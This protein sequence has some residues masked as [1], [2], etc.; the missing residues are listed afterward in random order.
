[1]ILRVL[2]TS[3]EMVAAGGVGAIKN[4]DQQ[5]GDGCA[6]TSEPERTIELSLEN[7]SVG[8]FLDSLGLSHL[9]DIFEKEQITMDILVE[10]G[11]DEL[12]DIGISAYGHRHKI[13]RRLE[14]LVTMNGQCSLVDD[15]CGW[16]TFLT[17]NFHV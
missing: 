9:K 5:A 12:K 7:L 16:S 11:H 8:T 15:H 1:M 4:S 10:M 13:I 3:Q 2:S 6:D 14:K 17:V